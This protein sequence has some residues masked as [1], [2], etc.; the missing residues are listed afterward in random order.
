MKV[1]RWARLLTQ[2]TTV[3]VYRFLTTRKKLPFSFCRKQT[4][5][6]G[7]V[8][9]LYILKRKHIYIS[10]IYVSVSKYINRKHIYMYIYI[11]SI[12]IYI[13]LHLSLSICML[14]SKRKTEAQAII[15]NPSTVCSRRNKRKLSVL[16]MD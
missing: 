8:F 9:C 4:E 1:H 12:Y 6:S 11:S 14:R 7:S 5:V 16:Q 10:S 15:H 13:Y 3:T 2:H